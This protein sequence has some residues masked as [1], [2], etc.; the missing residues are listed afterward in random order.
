MHASRQPWKRDAARL[1]LAL[2]ILSCADSASGGQT[3]LFGFE[4]AGVAKGV[5]C[6]QDGGSVV[7]D[8]FCNVYQPVC[9]YGEITDKRMR[10]RMKMNNL[11]FIELCPD[12]MQGRSIKELCQQ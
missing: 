5:L 10:L 2:T 4:I 1:I 7:V 11:T 3:C 9:R 8:T 12:K 6:D